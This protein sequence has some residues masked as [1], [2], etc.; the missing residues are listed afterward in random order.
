[1]NGKHTVFGRVV[2]GLEVLDKLEKMGSEGG[3]CSWC[4]G[5]AFDDGPKGQILVEHK[6]ESPYNKIIIS[7]QYDDSHEPRFCT[8]NCVKLTSEIYDER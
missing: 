7:T 3:K 6:V 2:S 5:N 1:M 4:P 8:K